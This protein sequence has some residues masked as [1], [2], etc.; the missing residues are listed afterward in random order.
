MNQ[1]AGS[2]LNI[3]GGIILVLLAIALYLL[4]SIVASR[5]HHHNATAIFILNLFL[6]WTFLGYIVA[7]VWAFTATSGSR[8]LPG[9]PSR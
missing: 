5:R 4:P 8:A 1:D 6:G 9:S 7:L 2:F 3:C